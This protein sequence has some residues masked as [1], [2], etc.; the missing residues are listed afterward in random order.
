MVLDPLVVVAGVF[1]KFSV[2]V[3]L[4]FV[5]TLNFRESHIATMVHSYQ[6]RST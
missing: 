4:G 5:A 3:F 6:A 1:D 2:C